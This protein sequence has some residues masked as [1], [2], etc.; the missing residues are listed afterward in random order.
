MTGSLD[1]SSVEV[2]GIRSIVGSSGNDTITGT[3]TMLSSS[4]NNMIDAKEGNDILAG[5]I[6]NDSLRG[7]SGNDRFIFLSN[8][9]S[10]RIEDFLNGVDVIDLVANSANSMADITVSCCDPR[11]SSRRSRS[12]GLRL[13]RERGWS[14]GR[15]A[16]R[17]KVAEPIAHCGE[18]GGV[19]GRGL[20]AQGRVGPPEVVVRHP[21]G[22]G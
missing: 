22:H 8:G 10:D 1:L 18:L 11:P 14:N 21:A 15:A 3:T 7:G 9:G 12:P 5:G 16:Q 19:G 2:D 13:A 17:V 4:L 20:I 6:G